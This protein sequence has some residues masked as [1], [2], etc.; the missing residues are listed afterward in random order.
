MQNPIETLWSKQKIQI[1]HW[2]H[3]SFENSKEFV[4]MLRQHIS[5]ILKIHKIRGWSDNT[6][7]GQMG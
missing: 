5:N 3:F 6:R 7:M 1:G 4:N 2:M